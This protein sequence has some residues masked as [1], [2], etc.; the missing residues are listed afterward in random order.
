M[1]RTLK[2][3]RH[4]Q[5]CLIAAIAFTFAMGSSSQVAAQNLAPNGEFDTDITSWHVGTGDS[6]VSWTAID[7]SGCSSTISG[8]ALVSNSAANASSERGSGACVTGI[9]S[10][11]T[12]SFGV[13][14]RFLTGQTRTGYATLVVAWFP[15]GT[16]DGITGM[17]DE[18]DLQP[19]T[20]QAGTWVHVRADQVIAPAGSLSAG[21]AVRVMKN[22]AGGSVA[23]DF[24]GAYFYARPGFIFGDGFTHPTSCHWSLTAP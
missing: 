13:D 14:I 16:C 1:I 9:I 12:Y 20:T 18:G 4:F 10:G 7:H 17:T 5:A 24:D 23:A 6:A 21:L 22:E 19:D 8:A 2:P 15:N 11:G 3:L